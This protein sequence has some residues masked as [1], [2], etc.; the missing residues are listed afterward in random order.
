[1]LYSPLTRTGAETDPTTVLP[2]L[3]WGLTKLHLVVKEPLPITSVPSWL[4]VSYSFESQGFVIRS[5][6]FPV[7]STKFKLNDC[8]ALPDLVLT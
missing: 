5:K 3:K 4:K 6:W 1:M 7:S 2:F 8:V